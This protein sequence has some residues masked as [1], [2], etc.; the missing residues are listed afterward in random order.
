MNLEENLSPHQSIQ[1][2]SGIKTFERYPFYTDYKPAMPYSSARF[3]PMLREE[4][5]KAARHMRVHSTLLSSSLPNSLVNIE[6]DPNGV[7]TT[8]K[9]FS[10][11]Q[12]LQ[13]R[14]PESKRYQ[15]QLDRHE[16]M[17]TDLKS[18]DRYQESKSIF[19]D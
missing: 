17:S 5:M 16:K 9:T 11:L 4:P 19:S 7:L 10:K 18:S 14:P 6:G 2:L 15:S 1:G 3:G 8:K 13:D 12:M